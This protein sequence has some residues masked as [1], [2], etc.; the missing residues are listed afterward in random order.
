[1]GQCS[2]SLSTRNPGAISHSRW[3]TTA[4][5]LLRLYVVTNARSENLTALVTFVM[6]VYAPSWF[7]IKSKPSCKDGARHLFQVIRSSRYLFKDLRDIIDPVIQRNAF[8]G[9]P[10]TLLLAM[11]TDELSVIRELGL[12]R[13][14]KARMTNNTSVREF[15]VPNINFDAHEYYDMLDFTTVE[16][17]QPPLIASVSDD[18]IRLL[19]KKGTETTLEFPRFPCHTQAIERCVKLVTEASMSVCGVE[20]RDGFT[21]SRLESRHIMPLFNT[22]S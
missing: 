5:R 6:R 12:R 10:E 3:L 19:V 8:S 14:L 18:E 7:R 11:I 22:K 9:H 13:I 17:T 20:S 2:P 4:S 21:R 15:V 1:M 16:V